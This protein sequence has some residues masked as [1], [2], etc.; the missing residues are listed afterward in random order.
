LPSFLIIHC[1]LSDGAE[2]QT[3]GVADSRHH[4]WR[5]ACCGTS[6]IY[7]WWE[8]PLSLSKVGGLVR[9]GNLNCS[10]V[11]RA[12]S[13][14]SGLRFVSQ[15]AS[16]PCQCPWG[17]CLPGFFFLVKPHRVHGSWMSILVAVAC[18]SRM[19]WTGLIAAWFMALGPMIRPRRCS[20]RLD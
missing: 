3:L 2:G 18:D 17:W 5:T 20:W 6:C 15:W 14:P 19:V 10:C 16:V 8:V 13:C 12:W 7:Y 4:C 9:P 1:S 11:R